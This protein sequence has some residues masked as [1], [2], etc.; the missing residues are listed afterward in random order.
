M[1]IELRKGERKMKASKRN[2]LE[3]KGWRLTSAEDFRGLTREE[4]AFVELK[5]ALADAVRSAA[6]E[7]STFR[8][9]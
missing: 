7:V 9:P 5:L 6:E 4:A 8:R 3:A 1:R 2:R